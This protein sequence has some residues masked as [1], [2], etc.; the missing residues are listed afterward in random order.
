MWEP[1]LA[2]GD[3]GWRVIAPHFRGFDGIA[4]AR[5]QVDAGG[6]A[7]TSPP[8]T[9]IDDYA[10]DVIDL[11]DALHIHEAVIVGLSMGGYVAMAML[12]HAARYVHALVLADTRPQADTPEG[13][14]ARERMRR[15]AQ[16]KGAA[17]IA[18][19]P[20]VDSL[21]HAARRGRRRHRDAT[22]DCRSD[23][24][25][26]RRLRADGPAR[27]GASFQPREH[28]R[29]QRDAFTLPRPSHL[30]DN[31]RSWFVVRRAAFGLDE[32]RTTNDER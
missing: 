6:A 8:V 10:G 20:L 17:A 11:L 31:R 21:S 16:E 9:S 7:E 14:D 5:G 27:I 18:D 22:L 13:V 28:R 30:V 4:A 1:Q 26:D 2:L 25:G 24:A 23:A 32:R 29:V 3:R 15:L 12:R 19:D